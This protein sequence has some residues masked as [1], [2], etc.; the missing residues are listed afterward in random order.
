MNITI[1]S[2]SKEHPTYP[3]I[4]KWINKNSKKHKIS[5]INKTKELIKG[6]L[7]LLVACN[8]IVKLKQRKKFKKTL[9]IHA[10]DLPKGRGWSPYIWEII[11]G[12]NTVT[13]SLIEAEDTPD[14]GN[15]WA[16]RSFNLEGHE[17]Y[18]EI[19]KKLNSVILNLIDFAVKKFDT[20]IPT[21]QN[22]SNVSYYQKR[23]P[24]D[25]KLD[26][27]KS[28]AEQFDLMRTSDVKRYPNF[29][30]HKGHYYKLTLSK[31]KKS[32]KS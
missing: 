31:F 25:S 6:D 30:Y 24:E 13:V 17:L 16:K 9:L 28:I 20:I 27:N 32:K 26:V 3:L 7:L 14:T 4:Q 8:E 2:T 11:N 1:L 22:E 21:P 10:S 23:I 18:D 29:F 12:K 15:I 19:F 5:L